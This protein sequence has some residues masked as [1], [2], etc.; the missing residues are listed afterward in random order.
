MQHMYIMSMDVLHIIV[1]VIVFRLISF[2][3]ITESPF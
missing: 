2:V 1:V 3:F